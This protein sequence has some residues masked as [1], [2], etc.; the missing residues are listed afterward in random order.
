MPTSKCL[1]GEIELK[2][3][4][5]MQ[6][7]ALCSCTNCQQTSGSAYSVNLVFPKGSMTATKGNVKVYQNKGDSGNE[8]KRCFCATCGSPLYSEAADGTYYVKGGNMQEDKG[9]EGK[10]NLSIFCRSRPDWATPKE[11]G[12][13][14]PGSTA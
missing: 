4:A 5:E 10:P 2:F 7:K 8:L 1:C 11:A 13:S 14:L 6:A 12:D 9:L 3:D